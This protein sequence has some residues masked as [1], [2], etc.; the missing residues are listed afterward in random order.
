MEILRHYYGDDIELV[1][2]APIQDIQPSPIPAAPLRLGS[3]GE[4]VAVVQ[5]MPQPHLPELPRHPQDP[6]RAPAVFGEDT[7]YSVR[8]FQRIF[9]LASDGVVG[10]ATWYK[11][12]YL[13]VGVTRLSELVSEGQTF[14]KV[15]FQYPGVLR[16]GDTGTEVQ[17]LQYMLA[18]LAEF[19]E[20]IAPADGGRRIRPLHRQCGPVLSAAD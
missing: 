7:E 19:D 8:Q 17:V 3:V 13:Y 4:E 20:V 12:V 6:A 9:N 1:I 11:L 5:T 18:V 15:Q 2:N 16:E 14:Y 10:K